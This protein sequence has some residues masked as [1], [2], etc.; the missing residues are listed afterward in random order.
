M[1]GKKAVCKGG[2]EGFHNLS[3]RGIFGS[4]AAKNTMKKL[5]VQGYPSEGCE[6]RQAPKKLLL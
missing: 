3:F 5:S 1:P 4:F 6:G 2:V